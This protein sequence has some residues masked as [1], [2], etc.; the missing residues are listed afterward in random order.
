MP[1]GIE[2]KRTSDSK[3]SVP[4]RLTSTVAGR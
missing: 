2:D 3:A 1:Y 4:A